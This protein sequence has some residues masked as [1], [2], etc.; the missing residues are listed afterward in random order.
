MS[1]ANGEHISGRNRDDGGLMDTNLWRDL[2][3]ELEGEELLARA[4]EE[5]EMKL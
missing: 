5:T 3:V 4:L 2:Q 1:G